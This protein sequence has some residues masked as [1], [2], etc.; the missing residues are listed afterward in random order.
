MSTHKHFDKIC[1]VVLAV[2]LLLTALLMFGDIPAARK[3][4][5]V[6]GYENKLFDVSRVHTV[7]I[8]MD[9]WDE[10]IESCKSEKYY[11]CAVVIDTESY[12]NVAIRGQGNTSLTRVASY[13]NNRYSF[14]IEFDHYD[15]KNT[16]YGLDK[17]CLNNII[18]DNT[19]I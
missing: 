3:T 17:L 18:Q 16:Y 15:S 9:N 1:C 12:K 19:Y 4:S 13:G 8:V 5:T 14:K 7:D 2:T 10:F 11:N 6:M